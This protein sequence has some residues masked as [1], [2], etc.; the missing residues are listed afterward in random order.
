MNVFGFSIADF[1][2]GLFISFSYGLFFGFVIAFARYA[3]FGMLE[4]KE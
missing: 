3:F 2:A 4:R 1:T